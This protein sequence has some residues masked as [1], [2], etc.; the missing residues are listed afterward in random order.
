MSVLVNKLRPAR[1]DLV[2]VFYYYARQGAV[3][4]ARRFLIQAEATM[5]RLARMPGVGARYE[6][7]E[8]VYGE[9]RYFPISRSRSYLVFYRPIEGGIEVVRVLH[10]ARDIHGVLADQLE[11]DANDE[12]TVDRDVESDEYDS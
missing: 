4:T 3:P 2:D 12:D 11:G 1:Q 7:D 5:K 6:P 9:L 10:G 8:P